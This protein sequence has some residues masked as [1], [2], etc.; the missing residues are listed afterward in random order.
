MGRFPPLKLNIRMFFILFSIMHM[1][2]IN[3]YLKM[4]R[5]KQSSFLWV[6]FCYFFLYAKDDSHFSSNF[7]VFQV[8]KAVL[9]VV[10][11]HGI[12]LIQPSLNHSHFWFVQIL[13][14]ADINLKSS[15]FCLSSISEQVKNDSY[16][17]SICLVCILQLIVLL[18]LPLQCIELQAIFTAPL[19]VMK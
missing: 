13:A 11:L 18:T 5:N 15:H 14:F 12:M 2:F 17:L 8:F 16:A 19:S 6:F 7:N 9:T 4:W 3:V 10:I 1:V